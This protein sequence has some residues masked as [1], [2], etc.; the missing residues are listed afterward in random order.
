MDRL[1]EIKKILRKEMLELMGEDC[2]WFM[3]ECSERYKRIREIAQKLEMDSKSSYR[4]RINKEVFE[5]FL[6][7][8]YSFRKIAD[9]FGVDEKQLKYWRIENGY[10]L[11]KNKKIRRK[12]K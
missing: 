6:K 1:K 7:K 5:D 2:N 12:I 3:D 4:D 10:V 11:H 9:F 8:G